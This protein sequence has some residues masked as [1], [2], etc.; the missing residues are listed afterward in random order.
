MLNPSSSPFELSGTQ[1][2]EAAYESWREEKLRLAPKRLDELIVAV[3]DPRNLTAAE[4]DKITTVCARANMVIYASQSGEDAD[5]DIP[6]ALA[7]QLNLLRPDSHLYA[8]DDGLSAITVAEA[9][10][11]TK[12]SGEADTRAAFIPYTDRPIRWHTDG[13]YNPPGYQVRG[14]LLHCVRQAPQGGENALMDHEMAY[15]LLRDNHPEVLPALMA[16]DAMTLPAHVVAGKELRPAVTGPVFSVCGD[17]RLHMRYTARTRSILWRDDPTTRAAVAA[18]EAL[19]ASPQT[20]AIFHAKL[21][22]GMGLV[23]NN[24]LHDRSAFLD[25]PAKPRLLYRGR[26]LDPVGHLA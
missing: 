22:P 13:Y 2:A 17:G 19:L 9:E 11:P 10:E 24:V 20:G 12:R 16:A 15:L 26:Y 4:I 14:M 8:E 6:R 21:M 3:R 7:R 5:P 18:L 25:D 23:C 1:A